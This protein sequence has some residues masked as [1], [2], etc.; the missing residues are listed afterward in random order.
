[1]LGTALAVTAL[2]ASFAPILSVQAGAGVRDI[3]AL[4]HVA[5]AAVL[6]PGL[7]RTDAARE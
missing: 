5:V 6:V 2:V 7:R 3:L 4:M 1:M